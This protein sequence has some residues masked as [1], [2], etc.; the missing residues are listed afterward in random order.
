MKL[1]D[2]EEAK[3]AL[4]TICDDYSCTLLSIDEIC[5]ALDSLTGYELLE[6]A[7]MADRNKETTGNT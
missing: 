5:A 2:P 4:R 7:E 6:P 1:I 3:R